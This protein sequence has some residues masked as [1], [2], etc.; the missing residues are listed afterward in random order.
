M[1]CYLVLWGIFFFLTFCYSKNDISNS[2]SL[3]QG[4]HSTNRTFVKNDTEIVDPYAY[5]WESD[6][7]VPV[8][9][10]MRAESVVRKGHV[11]GFLKSGVSVVEANVP[12]KLSVFGRWLER[13]EMI[14][15]TI[16]NCY[17]L[18]NN[19]SH[20]EFLFQSEMRIEF[21]TKFEKIA[22]SK[23][24]RMCISE[25]DFGQDGYED[26]AFMI[27][28]QRTWIST[29]V[30]ASDYLLPFH[31]QILIICILFFLSALFSGL[32]LGLMALSPQELTLLQKSGSEKEKEYATIILPVRQAGNFL[33][34]TILIMNV[35]V[36]SAISILFEDMTSGYIAFIVSSMGI[37]IFGEIFPQSLC[38]KKGL[39]VGAYTIWLTRFFMFLTFPL[40]FPIGKILDWL[41]GED[42]VV[43]DKKQ[44][45]QLMKLTPSWETG[46]T[47]LAADLKIAVGAMEISDKT[48]KDIMTSIE[49]V[50][51]LNENTILNAATITEIL[52]KG[53]SRIPVYSAD[54][55]KKITS[56]LFVKDLALVDPDD[57][58]TV[59]TI[60][61][62]YQHHVRFVSEDTGL[63]EMLDEFKKG[64]YHLAFVTTITNQEME[65]FVEPIKEFDKSSFEEE[66]GPCDWESDQENLSMIDFKVFE[67]Y[68]EETIVIGIVTLEDILEEILQAEIVDESDVIL[69]NVYK[70]KRKVD[71]TNHCYKMV[72]YDEICKNVSNALTLAC[73]QYLGAKSYIFRDAYLDPNTFNRVISSNVRIVNFHKTAID[74]RRSTENEIC[75]C[76]IK[77]R[78]PCDKIILILEG[79]CT[80]TFSSVQLEFTVGPFE[81][82][83]LHLVETLENYVTTNNTEK[84]L[85]KNIIN[86]KYIP[87]FSL[88]VTHFCR[89]LQLTPLNYAN[90][91]RITKALRMGRELNSKKLS[92]HSNDS[93]NFEKRL[94]LKI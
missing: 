84:L 31:V 80:V 32:N 25:K 87:D 63:Q 76:I 24:Y 93:I 1:K 35:I 67:E 19:I 30:Q 60:C 62:Y 46:N 90:I 43:Y 21:I 59:K 11:A 6:K 23:T 88:K 47:E 68:E 18:L 45:L 3:I 55:N 81:F 54:N 64:D 83:G 33:L 20:T 53:Y 44:V 85:A 71:N 58:F 17:H 73:S 52:K 70:R 39:A 78:V 72:E 56:I 48:V 42:I 15:F 5:E 51:M 92:I 77:E 2:T 57:K 79:T 66:Y 27:D 74:D 89:Y 8:V 38:I 82:F 49:D 37:V 65:N 75:M 9:C 29:D 28:E 36:N 14:S 12:I 94:S 69:D 40:S 10:G 16:D 7:V 13:V 91:Y 41:F 61:Q 34:C 22:E 50:F 86:L 4:S 26:M